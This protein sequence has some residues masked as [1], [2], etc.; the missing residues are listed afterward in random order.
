MDFRIN[1]ILLVSLENGSKNSSVKKVIQV[2]LLMKFAALSLID[3]LICR[4][5][6][7]IVT[8]INVDRIIAE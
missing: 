3:W 2:E 7:S 1:R 5:V 6:T 4:K 8:I